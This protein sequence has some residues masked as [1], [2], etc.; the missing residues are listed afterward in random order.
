M[1]KF[2]VISSPRSGTDACFVGAEG[3]SSAVSSLLKY[4]RVGNRTSKNRLA[5]IIEV[6]P[7]ISVC[8]C[9]VYSVSN[10]QGS[11]TMAAVVL[12]AQDL[13]WKTFHRCTCIYLVFISDSKVFSCYRHVQTTFLL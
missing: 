4:C 1:R 9:L 12:M 2:L 6:F 7:A 8:V 10:G 13:L 11:I 5:T 3:C